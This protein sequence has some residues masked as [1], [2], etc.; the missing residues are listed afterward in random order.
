MLR[1]AL[2]GAY[3]HRRGLRRASG[4]IVEWIEMTLQH[5][6]LRLMIGRIMRGGALEWRALTAL[7][8]LI[9]SLVLLVTDPNV[10]RL[11]KC[12]WRRPIRGRIDNG[13]NLRHTTILKT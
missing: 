13:Y 7:E 4:D 12:E 2:I 6:A 8:I 11:V 3:A 1:R 9:I 10:T 5:T